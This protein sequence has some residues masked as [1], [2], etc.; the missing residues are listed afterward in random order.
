[1]RKV[2]A[3]LMLFIIFLLFF[4]GIALIIISLTG[5]LFYSSN[6]ALQEAM[7]H[8]NYTDPVFDEKS[9]ISNRPK[10]RLPK[11][12]RNKRMNETEVRVYRQTFIG[13]AEAHGQQTISKP[14]M[15]LFYNPLAYQLT[16]G[17]LTKAKYFMERYK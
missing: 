15:I 11:W 13:S 8:F 16:R 12:H 3:F 7:F 17:I 5:L 10:S 14:K 6:D 9:T 4:A 1:M 2:Y